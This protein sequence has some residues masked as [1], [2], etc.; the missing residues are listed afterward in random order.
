MWL[1]WLKLTLY[2]LYKPQEVVF[3][4]SYRVNYLVCLL[5]TRRTNYNAGNNAKSML[6]W[7]LWFTDPLL[8]SGST[9][10][11]AVDQ[12]IPGNIATMHYLLIVHEAN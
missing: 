7:D 5:V 1:K 9:L 10:G 11:V 3:P 6:V 2:I 4:T 8:S 12:K